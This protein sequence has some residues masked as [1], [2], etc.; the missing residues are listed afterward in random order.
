M[1]KKMTSDEITDVQDAPHAFSSRDISNTIA[2]A[3]THRTVLPNRRPS[4]TT[5]AVWRTGDATHRFTIT[6]GF[7]NTGRPFE[8]FA[9]NA[10]GDM[11]A[12]LSDA[13]VWASLCLQFG[14]T[15]A[16]LAKSL[17]RVPAWVNGALGEVSASPLGVIAEVIMEV[18]ARD[19]APDAVGSSPE[20]HVDDLRGDVGPRRDGPVAGAIRGVW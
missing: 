16:Y 12:M 8:V 10:K 18:V 11:A 19:H 17:G 1:T 2:A 13:C 9:D 7:S 5:E 6:V 3:L 15:P 14:A 20:V 4:V